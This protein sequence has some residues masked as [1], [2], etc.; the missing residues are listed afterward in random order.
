[1]QKYGWFGELGV[2]QGH[3]VLPEI[4]RHHSDHVQKQTEDVI[5]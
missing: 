3:E 2:T 4:T 5:I 1:M